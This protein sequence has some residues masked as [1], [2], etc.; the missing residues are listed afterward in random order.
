MYYDYLHLIY[1]NVSD[2]VADGENNDHDQYFTLQCF[3]GFVSLLMQPCPSN[4]FGLK[5]I[6]KEY[7]ND[8]RFKAADDCLAC[9]TW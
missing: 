4:L 3:L 1:H 9:P 2:F 5:F 8:L 7:L 6:P